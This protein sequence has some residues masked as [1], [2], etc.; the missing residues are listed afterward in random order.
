MYFMLWNNSR[1]SAEIEIY[2]W[3]TCLLQVVFSKI[4]EKET[5]ATFELLL[6]NKLWIVLTKD[7]FWLPL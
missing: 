2:Y 4:T 6:Q 5:I 3:Y 7:G 1:L